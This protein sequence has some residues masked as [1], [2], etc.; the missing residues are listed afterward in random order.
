DEHR[1]DSTRWSPDR[2][3]ELIL[4]K[5]SDPWLDH[6][7]RNLSRNYALQQRRFLLSH[8][9]PA[10]GDVDV[11]D[12]RGLDVETLQVK[13]S[14]MGLSGNTVRNI[15]TTLR[16]LLHWLKKKDV[17]ERVPSFPSLSALPR[18]NVG[19]IEPETQRAILDHIRPD[20]R[21]LVETMMAA[22][23][24]PGEA[25]AWKVRDLQG[26]ELKIERALTPRREVK[27]TKTG[28]VSSHLIAEGLYARL[29]EHS[30]GKLPEAWLFVNAAGRPYHTTQVS[31]L[32]RQAA[33]KAGVEV[34]LYVAS[35][36][37]RVSQLRQEL[38]RRVSEELRKELAHESSRTTMKHY[39]RDE[40]ELKR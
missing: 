11:R 10:M 39:C 34:C 16:T 13:L 36:H 9:I 15:L 19:W 38:E 8:I 30:R 37:S 27:S 1:F 18:A 17:I 32:W 2:R 26:G 4:S 7:D 3:K 23:A 22:G 29:K 28:A 31:W 21:L 12:I 14:D 20:V 6:L 5:I 24:R 35:R 33:V 25:V 40:R